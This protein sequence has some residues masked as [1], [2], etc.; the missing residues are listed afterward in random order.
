[1][2]GGRPGTGYLA[3]SASGRPSSGDTE[4]IRLQAQLVAHVSHDLRGALAA[5]QSGLRAL[6][7]DLAAGSD[8]Q[9]TAALSLAQV[10]RAR[11]IVEEVL[12]LSR[13][14]RL[15]KTNLPVD[16]VLAGLADR[17]RPQALEKG[18]TVDTR[19]A[20]GML[21]SADRSN[22]EAAFGNLV[23]NALRAMP[24]GGRLTLTLEPEERSSAG[25]L[26][27]VGDTGVGIRPELGATVFEA[28][29]SDSPGGSGLGLAIARHVVL[30]HGGQIDFDTE[31]GKG[32]TFRVWLPRLT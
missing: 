32:T 28:F 22:L 29:V 24:A 12:A 13:P 31:V 21:V 7:D 2:P 23:E 16:E 4:R 25:V 17:Y 27:C 5:V 18:V 26:V 19:L 1:V 30:A 8:E 10:E 15:R 6:A 20:P 11:R 14:G 3:L 9:E